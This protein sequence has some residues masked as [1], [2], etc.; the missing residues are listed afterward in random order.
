MECGQKSEKGGERLSI[1]LPWKT[2]SSCEF[3]FFLRQN[4]R[5]LNMPL[6]C[7]YMTSGFLVLGDQDVVFQN[8]C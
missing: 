1:E 7:L 2:A 5:K 3:P 4:P 6:P 8:V